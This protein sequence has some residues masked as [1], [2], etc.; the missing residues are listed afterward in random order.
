MNITNDVVSEYLQDHY[1]P[2][3]EELN[4][5]RIEAEENRVPIILK[6]T[7]SFLEL[8]LKIVKPKKIL[9]I[10]S[11]VGYSASFMAACL[12]D[13]KIFTI[14]KDHDVYE[15]AKAKVKEL[16][17]DNRITLLEGDGEECE[18]A[19]FEQGESDF[20]L[21]FIDAA[22]SHY[23]RFFDASLRLSNKDTVFVCDN[24]L[25]KARTCSDEYDPNHKYKTNIRN[26][27]EFIEYITNDER[28]ETAVIAVG[29]GLSITRFKN[30]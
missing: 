18:N 13:A 20:D 17:Y 9:E 4:R 7:E 26:M 21:V 27:R 5:L 15:T 14:E 3:N 19:L 10:G 11:A 22:K 1:K 12:P 30:E 8:F 2:L 6:E 25:F 28:F 23:K 29:D 24:V 16:A